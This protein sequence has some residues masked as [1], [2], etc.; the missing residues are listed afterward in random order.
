MR[1]LPPS[2][3]QFPRAYPQD[4]T[5][6]RALPNYLR[7]YRKRGGFTQAEVAFLLGCRH[8]SKV[9]R[10]E[11]GIRVPSLVGLI[12]YEVIF[13]SLAKTL[14]AGTYAQVREDVRNRARRLSKEL[15]ARP[16]TPALKQKLDALVEIIYSAKGREAA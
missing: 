15:D 2:C 7:T 14:F 6:L 5:V 8:R 16:L 4:M 11:R 10:Y 3:A 13:R 1:L 9:S 12:G